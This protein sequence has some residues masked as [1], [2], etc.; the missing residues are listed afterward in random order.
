M[1]KHARLPASAAHRWTACPASAYM[2]ESGDRRGSKYAAEGTAAHFL[3]E[4]C[5]KEG[6]NP[7]N[8]MGKFISVDPE[9]VTY[10]GVAEGDDWEFEVD[11]EMVDAATTFLQCTKDALITMPAITKDGHACTYVEERVSPGHPELGGTLDWAYVCDEHAAIADLKYGRGVVVEVHDNP[12]QMIYA[13]GLIARH[14]EI[15]E[16]TTYIVQPRAPHAD[17]PIRWATYSARELADF[18]KWLLGKVEEAN[19]PGA[20]RI[21]GEHC[22][23]CPDL[24]NCQAALE[25]AQGAAAMEFGEDDL[26]ECLAECLALAPMVEAWAKAV[27]KEALSRLMDEQVV[28]GWKLVHGRGTRDWI[29]STKEVLRLARK[30]GILKALCY[31]EPKLLSPYGLEQAAARQ[32]MTGREASVHFSELWEKAPGNPTI[33]PDD[34][35]REPYHNDPAD[36]FAVE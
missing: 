22:R 34:D 25:M 19:T 20:P 30:A 31:S 1:S 23:F 5:L 11:P 15:Q 28:L 26:G 33:A 36:D 32:G 35:P 29:T 17:G 2:D 10:L 21:A 4:Q 7:R 18:Y 8:F 12:Q 3:V 14:P 24:A 27:R 16:V 6:F 9:S 13:L